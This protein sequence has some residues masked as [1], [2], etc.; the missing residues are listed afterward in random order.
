MSN[1]IKITVEYEQPKADKFNE[2]LTQYHNIKKISD[3]TISYYKPLA[4][5][6]NEKK[7]ELIIEQVKT[8]QQYLTEI[9]KLDNR[10]N[11]VCERINIAGTYRNFKVF[12]DKIYWY[13]EPFT[14]NQYITSNDYMKGTFETVFIKWDE[15]KI[16]E[17]LEKQCVDKL[18][19]IIDREKAKAEKQIKRLKNITEV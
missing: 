6:A 12:S 3:D 4:D 1:V 5:A 14:M 16:Y 2:L 17:S 10:Y 13:D 9:N 11:V 8:I 15:L 7:M 18:N 19:I